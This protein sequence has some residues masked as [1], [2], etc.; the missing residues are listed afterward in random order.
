[1]ASSA[2]VATVKQNTF[3]NVVVPTTLVENSLFQRISRDHCTLEKSLENGEISLI[4]HFQNGT[5]VDGQR[6]LYQKPIP[7]QKDALIALCS[8]D[9]KVNFTYYDNYHRN[10]DH[11]FELRNQPWVMVNRYKEKKIM[12]VVVFNSFA[13]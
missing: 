7:I 3:N 11:H 2:N 5:F 10:F 9:S 12:N 13:T 6:V 4:S 8:S 1:L